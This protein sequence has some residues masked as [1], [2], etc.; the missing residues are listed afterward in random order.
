MIICWTGISAH[1][2][3]LLGCLSVEKVK[4]LVLSELWERLSVPIIYIVNQRLLEIVHIS[5]LLVKFLVLS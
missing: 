2:A 3:L 4:H 1:L 5:I